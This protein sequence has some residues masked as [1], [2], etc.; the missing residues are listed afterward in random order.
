MT[1]LGAIDDGAESAEF[2]V[3]GAQ[4]TTHTLNAANARQ[5][6]TDRTA[7]LLMLQ[8]WKEGQLRKTVSGKCH[9]HSW[10]SGERM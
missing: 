10:L 9:G 5:K 1:Q 7:A 2:I 4:D 6:Q 3:K 8:I